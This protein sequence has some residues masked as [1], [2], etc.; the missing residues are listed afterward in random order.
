MMETEG[1]D[2]EGK[3]DPIISILHKIIAYCQKDLIIILICLLTILGC[4]ITW[5]NIQHVVN[6]CNDFYQGEMKTCQCGIYERSNFT[7]QIKFTLTG[8]EINASTD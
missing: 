7:P 8:G 4:I 6:E 5:G 3:E 1:A 2:P